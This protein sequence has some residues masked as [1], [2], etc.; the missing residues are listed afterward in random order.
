MELPGKVALVTGAGRRVGRAL[1]LALAQKGA[2]VAVHF[3]DSDA[4]ARDVATS[5]RKGGARAETFGA[6]LTKPAELQRLVDDV[7]KTLGSLDVL[8]NSAAI[9][10]RTPFGE[11]GVDDWDRIFALN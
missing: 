5:I 6:D 8:I 3:K 9:M 7:V 2:S 11:V 10:E 1:A 4:G